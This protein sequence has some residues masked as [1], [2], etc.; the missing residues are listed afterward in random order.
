MGLGEQVAL[1]T[2]GRFS[3]ATKGASIG[4]IS[5]EAAE[6]GLIAYVEEG[7]EIAI[8][9]PARSICLKVDDAILQK[10]KEKGARAPR[11]ELTGYLKRYQKL[12]TS[13]SKGAVL[14][15]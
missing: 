14:T 13:A 4:H 12:V 15:D 7:D 2:D 9:I 6:G 8:D 3:G 11:Q 1:I 10:R 5:P